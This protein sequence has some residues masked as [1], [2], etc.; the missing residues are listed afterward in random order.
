MQCEVHSWEYAVRY[1]CSTAA[2]LGLDLDSVIWDKRQSIDEI[3]V[4]ATLVVNTTV[5]ETY[6]PKLARFAQAPEVSRPQ[7]LYRGTMGQCC[8]APRNVGVI[9]ATG[10]NADRQSSSPHQ[11]VGV[12]TH[13]APR[14]RQF[15]HTTTLAK[16]S[17]LL[18]A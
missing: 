13:N 3:Q 17:V 11:Q 5:S 1:T 8:S 9:Q 14:K 2:Q 18:R 7:E 6:L 10:G 4:L 12:L 15:P 16:T